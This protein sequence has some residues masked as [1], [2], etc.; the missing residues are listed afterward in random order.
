MVREVYRCTD[1]EA[2][3]NEDSYQ[4]ALFKNDPPAKMSILKVHFSWAQR[5]SL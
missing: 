1:Y 2:K 4:Q 5:L 3:G